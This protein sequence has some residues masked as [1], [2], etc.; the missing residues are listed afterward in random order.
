MPLVICG[1]MP[2]NK[3]RGPSCSMIYDITSIKLLNGLPWRAG[4]GRDCSPT[5]ATMSGC[6]AIVANALDAAPRTI[7]GQQI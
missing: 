4:G 1:T 6:V 5:F 2:L 3:A 7:D